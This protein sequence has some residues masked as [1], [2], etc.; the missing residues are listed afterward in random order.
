MIRR[1]PDYARPLFLRIR[2][3]MEVTSTFKY[4][5]T[6]L[7]RQ[8]Y[9]PAAT[10]S[11]LYF[12]D[13]EHEAFVRLDRRSTTASKPASFGSEPSTADHLVRTPDVV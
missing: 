11:A 7:V 1:L 4:T 6:D 9:D 13:P 8:G 10:T 2:A 12:N 3:E 5:K